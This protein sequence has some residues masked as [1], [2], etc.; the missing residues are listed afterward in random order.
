MKYSNVT[1][2]ITSSQVKLLLF[3]SNNTKSRSF[4][5]NVEDI[6]SSSARLSDN[7]TGY[8]NADERF[9]YSF[10][11]DSVIILLPKITKYITWSNAY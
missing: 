8:K 5:L 10:K 7:H 1:D 11:L 9:R 3:F 2:I 4:F 6:G